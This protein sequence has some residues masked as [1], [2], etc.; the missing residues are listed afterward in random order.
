MIIGV[1]GSSGA[2]K[3]TLANKLSNK[4]GANIVD[5]DKIAKDLSKKGNKYYD[6]ILKT[7]G[8]EILQNDCEID[9]SKLANIV[10][11]DNNKMKKLNELTHK[12]VADKIK[13]EALMLAE[14]GTVII[15]VPLLIESGLNE[16]CDIVVSILAE[17]KIKIERITKRDNISEEIAEKR[18]KI[19]PKDEFYIKNS[20]YIIY[21]N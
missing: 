20:N 15:D 6:C 9:R 21:N 17:D 5:A 4:L 10:Y 11:S 1:T 18:L 13:E 12:Y 3:T 2:G 14:K 19:Q 8:E 16:I 7:F